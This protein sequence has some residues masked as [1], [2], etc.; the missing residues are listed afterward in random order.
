MIRTDIDVKDNLVAWVSGSD[1]AGAVSGEIFKDRRPL[2]SDKEDI[3]IS[4]LSRTADS[5]IQAF[6][7]NV[8][9]YVKDLQRG[10]ETIENTTRIRVLSRISA[11]LFEYRN[12]G[13]MLIR[14]SSQ[15]VFK[16][17][18]IPWHVINNRLDISYNNEE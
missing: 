13:D 4:V 18:D 7:V 14:L 1:L 11:D 2:N 6:I 9:I 15:E 17:N 16:A 10:Q 12:T 3:V 5:Q 8:N